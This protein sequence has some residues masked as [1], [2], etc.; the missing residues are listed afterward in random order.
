MFRLEEL[1]YPDTLKDFIKQIA[2]VLLSAC[3]KENVVV[4]LLTGSGGRGELTIL[5]TPGG[6]E[7]LGDLE[8]I[9]ISTKRLSILR[10]NI[11]KWIIEDKIRHFPFLSESF[12]VDFSIVNPEVLKEANTVLMWE[13]LTNSCILYG[14]LPFDNIQKQHLG[15]RKIRLKDIHNILL[16]RHYSVF[17]GIRK[18]KTHQCRFYSVIRNSLDLLTAILYKNGIFIPSYRKR[19]DYLKKHSFEIL[20]HWKKEDIENFVSFIGK[21]TFLKLEP[22]YESFIN[23]QA[24]YDMLEKY[25]FFSEMILL[26]FL[27]DFF[28][29]NNKIECFNKF[30]NTRGFFEKGINGFGFLKFFIWNIK[31]IPVSFLARSFPIELLY[32]LMHIQL[33][34]KANY[35]SELLQEISGKN[36]TLDEKM[37]ERIYKY[38]FPYAQHL[39]INKRN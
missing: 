4:L 10:K 2:K 21:C 11:L 32:A 22:L 37:I 17:W 1:N 31:N 19:Y 24:L 20:P 15:E 16:Y 28:K 23:D 13:T 27:K 3:G 5:E 33:C 12:H 39:K 34:E 30:L 18:C 25:L 35:K 38:Y 9:V 26:D 8:F 6:Y 14:N 36:I 29:C 7:I